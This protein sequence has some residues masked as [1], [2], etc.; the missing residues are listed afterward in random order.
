[1]SEPITKDLDLAV[2]R[3]SMLI[4]EPDRTPIQ[5][6]FERGGEEV[7]WAEADAADIGLPITTEDVGE[8]R[9]G[10]PEFSL[11]DSVAAVANG[12]ARRAIPTGGCLWIEFET[13]GSNLPMVPWEK[14]LHGPVGAPIL[15]L[16]YF[17]TQPV[18]TR[19][20]FDV[21]L[22][23]SSPE[24]KEHLDIEHLLAEYVGLIPPSVSRDAV[25]H[26]F[27]DGE[28]YRKVSERLGQNPSVRIY[29]PKEAK[30]YAPA[31]QTNEVEDYPNRI[32]NPWLRWMIDTIN[33]MGRSIDVAH[34][35]CHGRLS[36]TQTS[37]AFAEAPYLNEDK[38]WARFVGPQQ[39]SL[40][41][42]AVGAWSVG[43][44]SPRY[45]L[46]VLGSRMMA[47]AV[48]RARPG[49]VFLL[50]EAVEDSGSALGGVY[51]FL[52]HG[53]RMPKLG[54]MPASGAIT[55]YCH[56]GHVGHSSP[57]SR[58]AESALKELTLGVDEIYDFTDQEKVSWV[59][60]SQRILEESVAQ[61]IEPVLKQEE[62]SPEKRAAEEVL[63]FAKGVIEDY[64]KGATP[65]AAESVEAKAYRQGEASESE[66][67]TEVSSATEEAI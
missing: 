11:P 16:P 61:L 64:A 28:A 43:F 56:P 67:S 6:Q 42:S 31:A 8:L 60:A 33:S 22:C 34:F 32:E 24:A 44:T 21:L 20:P 48:A 13:R 25:I 62:D 23:A 12:F 50:D 9:H 53:D 30:S 17:A 36:V 2:L 40:F 4:N 5:F 65:R 47:D 46:S 45:N 58:R 10:M 35:I 66:S 27:T 55:L 41:L 57:A 18:L 1:M 7:A 3:I 38:E 19:G 49:P 15:R 14:L 63:R 54:S 37:L 39:L 26:I 51:K 52:Y 59:L 29:D